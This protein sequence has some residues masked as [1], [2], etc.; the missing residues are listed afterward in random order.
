MLAPGGARHQPPAQALDGKNGL[1]VQMRRNGEP[2][3]RHQVE[4]SAE[5]DVMRYVGVNYGKDGA[6]GRSGGEVLLGV[7]DKRSGHVTLLPTGRVFSMTPSIKEPLVP[8]LAPTDEQGGGSSRDDPGGTKRKLVSELG[9]SKAQKKQRA[10]TALQI[11]ADAVYNSAELD[12]D[13]ATALSAAA[14]SAERTAQEMHPLHPPFDPTATTVAAAYPRD[15]MVPPSLWSSLEYK[16]L[17]D[18]AKKG[19]AELRRIADDASRFTPRYVTDTLSRPLPADKEARKALLRGLCYLTYALRF[20]TIDH[21]I[22][23]RSGKH[24]DEAGHPT[25]AK[26]CIPSLLWE[27][28][29]REFTASDTQGAATGGG[30][31]GKRR[32][33]PSSREKLYLHILALALHLAGGTLPAAALAADMRL[34]DEKVAFYLRQLGCKL[35]K[36]A[37]SAE[38]VAV[39]QLPLVFPKL[40]RGAP[41]RR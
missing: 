18:A 38:R 8:L 23:A 36:R 22:S 19:A 29:L 41:K 34:T 24:G 27:H 35:E 2:R 3:K 31:K 30:R 14:P 39:L 7:H 32:L 28:L 33:T 21:P 37:G 6:A 9:S 26:L 4:V 20:A 12:A 40:G 25:A 13:V 11:K 10:N 15:G 5:T 17:R 16:A 1:K